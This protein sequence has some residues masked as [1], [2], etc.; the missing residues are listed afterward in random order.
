M[1]SMWKY[2][3]E[4]MKDPQY[5]IDGLMD[6]F[7]EEQSYY[8]PYGDTFTRSPDSTTLKT[9]PEW[10][11]RQWGE[12][13]QLKAQV[14]FLSNKINLMRANA[15]KRKPNANISKLESI[16]KGRGGEDEYIGRDDVTNGKV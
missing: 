13:Q 10:S 4:A 7:R 8:M 11:R 1:Y 5:L 3:N 16:Y 15:S 14:L 6:C 2:H 9:E 12:V